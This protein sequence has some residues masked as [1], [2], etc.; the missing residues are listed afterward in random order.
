MIL[1]KVAYDSQSQQFR[2]MDPDHTYMFDDG[3][4]YLVAVDI[5]PST[6]IDDDTVDV[7]PAGIGHA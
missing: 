2:L 1:V 3:E 7:L 4:T 5:F 6:F